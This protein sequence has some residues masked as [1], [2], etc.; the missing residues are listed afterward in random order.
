MTQPVITQQLQLFVLY[1][2]GLML[3]TISMVN[4]VNALNVFIVSE[5]VKQD[6]CNKMLSHRRETALQGE[7]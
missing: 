7:L 1:H 5:I 2:I 6:K 3:V 4:T